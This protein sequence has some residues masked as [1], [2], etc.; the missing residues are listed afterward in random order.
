M[1]K[2]A[3]RDFAGAR[4][5]FRTLTETLGRELPELRAL[6]E[7]LIQGRSGP[8]Y[9]VETPVVYNRA[10]DEAGPD[11][12]FKLILVADNPGRRE[13]AA[14]NR[15]YL[16]GPSGKLAEKF[17]SDHP[18]WGIGFREDVLILNK[19]PIHTPRTAELRDLG[20][21]G[22]P[23]AAAALARGL[24]SSQRVMAELLLDFHRA[25]APIPVWITGYSE[26]RQGGVFQAYTETLQTL[27]RN[28]LSRRRELLL[29]CHFSMHQFTIDLKRQ[30]LPG[31]SPE[32]SLARI[33]TAYRER[34]L[35]W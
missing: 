29:F 14:E 13:Q 3:W 9:P 8:A 12:E 27:Y 25:L 33:G 16:V 22:S 35:G 28:S 31:E 26:M 23:Q 18:A 6:Q 30:G 17:F 4:D 15:R 7:T 32:E 11:T 10:L 2:N 21:G 1:K 20:R 24:E 5:R 34:V 19:T